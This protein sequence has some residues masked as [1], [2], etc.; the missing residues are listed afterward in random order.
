MLILGGDCSSREHDRGIMFG[1]A[2]PEAKETAM[3]GSI[4]KPLASAAAAEAKFGF[5]PSAPSENCNIFRR[6]CISWNNLLIFYLTA[7]T[8]RPGERRYDPF[9]TP[10]V[11]RQTAVEVARF[12]PPPPCP[13]LLR[14]APSRCLMTCHADTSSHAATV[15]RKLSSRGSRSVRCDVRPAYQS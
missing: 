2:A 4:G 3:L 1:F 5:V 10:H 11:C 13:F 6:S 15:P 8:V 14:H 12:P 9:Q 7:S